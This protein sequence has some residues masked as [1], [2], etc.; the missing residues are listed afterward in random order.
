MVSIDL[1]PIYILFWTYNIIT[2]FLFTYIFFLWMI[3]ISI[4]YHINTW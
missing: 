4:M 2:S 3:H 1:V